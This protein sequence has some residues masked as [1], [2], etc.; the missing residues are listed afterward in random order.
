MSRWPKNYVPKGKTTNKE[1]TNPA[2]TDKAY[3]ERARANPNSNSRYGNTDDPKFSRKFE[4]VSKDFDG[5]EIVRIKESY[6]GDLKD[7]RLFAVNKDGTVGGVLNIN[8]DASVHSLKEGHIKKNEG[9]GERLIAEAEALYDRELNYDVNTKNTTIKRLKAD[10]AKLDDIVAKVLGGKKIGRLWSSL[11]WVGGAIGLGSALY[12][13]QS[14]AG[15]LIDSVDPTGLLAP[16]EVEVGGDLPP[17][18]LKERKEFNEKRARQLF[19][20]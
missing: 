9:V 14:I 3:I 4:V 7:D 13:G 6:N 20:E 16:A 12:S 18:I 8:G 10:P 2:G 19:E 17:E 11:P 5:R 15:A 1:R